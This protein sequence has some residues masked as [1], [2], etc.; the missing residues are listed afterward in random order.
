MNPSAAQLTSLALFGEPGI[1][2]GDAILSLA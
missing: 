2:V 1:A